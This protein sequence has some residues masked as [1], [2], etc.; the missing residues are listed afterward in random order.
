MKTKDRIKN[1]HA[2]LDKAEK[3]YKKGTKGY[4]PLA[5]QICKRMRQTIERAI[6]EVLLADIVQR[7]RRNIYASK[8]KDLMK[9]KKD[10]CVFLDGL[11][12]EYSKILH[13]QAEEARVPL[14]KPDKLRTDIKSLSVW[15]TDYNKREIT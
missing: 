10:D 11:M 7:Y 13:D 4:E 9:I 5:E 6:E 2:L 14:P 1:I 8:V 15:T 12:T 3:E